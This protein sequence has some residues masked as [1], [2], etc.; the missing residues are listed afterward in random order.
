[1]KYLYLILLLT[2]TAA[3]FGRSGSDTL[4]L[5]LQQVVEMAK[6][7]SIAAK[8]AA[9]VRETK[10]WEYRTYQSN[11]QPQL[12]LSG[13][14]PGYTKT[15]SQVQQPDGTILFQP[16]HNDNSSLQLNFSQSIAATGGTIYGTTQ[17]QRFDDFDRHNVLYNGIPY[18]INYAQPLFQFNKLKWDKKIEPLKFNESKQAY[19]EA[20]EKIAVDVEG[21]FF[22]LLLAQVNLKIAET[23]FANTQGI[24]K[25]ANLKYELGK[26]SK[27][28]I[29]QLR[30]E[31]INAQKAVGTAKRDMEIATLNLRSFTGQVGD[32]N[33]VLAVPQ[34]I[35]NMTVSS[36]KVLAEAYANRSDAIGFSRRLAEAKRD[37]ALA[38]GQNGLTATLTASL[39]FSNTAT[40][41]PDVYKN[42]QNQQQLQVQLSVPI[43]DWGRS[44]SR[45][46]TALANQQLTE[47]AVEQ[48]KQTFKQVI[49]TQVSLFNVTREQLVYTAQADSIAGEK[50]HIA[51]ERYLL[52]DLS[53]TDL[54]IAFR[55]NDQAQRDYVAALRDF[56]GAYYQLRYLSLYDFETNKKITYN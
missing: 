39:G 11:Y 2:I 55:E 43:L 3:A 35:S 34:D 45:T 18:G 14:L 6:A 1:M 27:N 48:D 4:R 50:Y 46:K 8:Q 23:N 37:V 49:V 38:K 5:T 52:G 40:S 24:L 30:L 25:V 36:D 20:Q 10:Y 12:A 16:I 32:D 13:T 22:D 21:Y 31:Q 15:F 54:G 17:L 47:Y 53:I 9:T 33:I 42:P 7:N 41:I 26:V 44:K 29:L 28:D 19:I 56:W 51:R